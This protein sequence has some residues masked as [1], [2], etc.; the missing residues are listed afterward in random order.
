MEQDVIGGCRLVGVVFI[1]KLVM[2]M[3]RVSKVGQFSSQHFYLFIGEN[4]NS[5]GVSM[6][7]K[8]I[9]LILTQAKRRRIHI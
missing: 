3:L 4:S 6:F 2:G 5:S 9:D 7:V 8:E 1:K